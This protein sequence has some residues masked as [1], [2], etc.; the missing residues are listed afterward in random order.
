MST[1]RVSRAPTR[2]TAQPVFQQSTDVSVNWKIAVPELEA[3]STLYIDSGAGRN[4]DR[5]AG[6]LW[7]KTE[8]APDTLHYLAIPRGRPD[9]LV[10]RER[11]RL[12]PQ[13]LKE[14]VSQ[15]RPLDYTT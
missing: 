1:R 8:H 15:L 7:A 14:L 10:I 2:P 11:E 4:F 13:K 9:E 3:F 5:A 12:T 6:Q